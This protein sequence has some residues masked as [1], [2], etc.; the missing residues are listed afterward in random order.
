MAS[1]NNAVVAMPAGRVT[2]VSEGWEEEFVL[3]VTTTAK[4]LLG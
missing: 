4:L 3:A 2:E 1:G